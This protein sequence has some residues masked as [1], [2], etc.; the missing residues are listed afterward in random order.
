MFMF[1]FHRQSLKYKYLCNLI[2]AKG[3]REAKWL[4]EV[5]SPLQSIAEQGLTSSFHVV[6][7]WSLHSELWHP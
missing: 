3:T 7:T 6:K 2:E 1:E 5:S 4:R